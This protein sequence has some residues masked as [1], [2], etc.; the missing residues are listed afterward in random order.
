MGGVD[1]ARESF[2]EIVYPTWPAAAK[3]KPEYMGDLLNLT[4]LI[5][6]LDHIELGALDLWIED[7]PGRKLS[8]P[9]AA[10]RLIGEAL[11]QK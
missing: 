1:M 11:V 7:R 9:E 6:R 3:A 2:G 10:R 8:R 4:P 5:V